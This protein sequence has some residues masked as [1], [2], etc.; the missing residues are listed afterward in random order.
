[1]FRTV[2]LQTYIQTIFSTDLDTFSRRKVRINR[3]GDSVIHHQTNLTNSK[4]V[5]LDFSIT[6]SRT[7]EYSSLLHPPAQTLSETV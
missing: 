4:N 1:M 7:K 5:R 3:A 6:Q 2:S